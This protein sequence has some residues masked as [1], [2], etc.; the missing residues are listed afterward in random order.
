[1]HNEGHFGPLG[2]GFFIAAACLVGFA[3]GDFCSVADG[4]RIDCF[5]QLGASEEK[6]Q[7]R[8]CCWR[9]PTTTERKPN[10]E[11]NK[12]ENLRNLN[13]PYCFYPS[14]TVGYKVTSNKE[15]ATGF[16]L[17]LQLIGKGCAYGNDYKELVVN[18]AL[19]TQT[20][21]HVTIRD[22]S[23][24]RYR[25]PIKTPSVTSKSASQD[26]TLTYNE[27]NFSFVVKRKSNGAVIFNTALGPFFFSKQFIQITSVLPSTNVYGLGEHVLGLKL[28]TEWNL[29]TLF[30]RDIG[31]PPG[32]VNLYGVHPFYLNV[33]KDGNA[34]GVFLLNSNAMDIIL[35]PNPAITYRT[36]G[37]VLDFY[38]F[39][40][41][42]PND[43]IEQYTNVIGTSVVPPY[44]SLGFHLCR[45]GYGTLS[46]MQEVDKRM[47]DNNIPLDTQWNDIEYMQDH[48]DFTIGNEK[49][50]GLPEYVN[51]LHA[52]GMH[53]V[54]IVDPG[55]SNTHSDYEAY[56]RGLQLG[57]FVKDDNGQPIVGKVWPGNTV[58]PDFFHPNATQYWTEQISKFH[59]QI[60]FD[61]LWIDMNEPSNFVV[62]SL[63]GCP[64]SSLETPPYV[65][66][67]A[68]GSLSVQTLCMTAKHYTGR[69]YDLHSL[70]GYSEG[71]V[72]MN[73][74]NTVRKKRS[75]VIGRSTFS[76]SGAHQ[77]H[78]TGDNHAS[79]DD[80]AK[81]IP[82]ILNFQMF[83]IP[84]VGAD[85][86][87]F[88]GTT[89]E[90]LCS[91][92]MQLGAFYPFS[93]NHNTINV[94]AQDP[95]AFG[96]QL[97]VA[98]RNALMLR[99]ALLP[100]LYTL[101]Y[102]SHLH[103]SPVA[104]PLFFNFPKDPNT[105]DIDQQFMWGHALLISPV[106]KQ[107]ASSVQ[108]YFPAGQW[109]SINQ[110][111]ANINSTGKQYTLPGSF[112][113]PNVHI[114]GGYIVPGQGA[115]LTTTASRKNP[116]TVT[117][118]L[119]EG[120]VAYGNMFMD[121]GE[122]SDDMLLHYS[123]VTFVAREKTLRSQP[124]YT[125]YDPGTT[126]DNVIIYGVKQLPSSVS[127]NGEHTTNFN[128]NAKFQ[129]LTIE[130]MKLSLLK[131]NKISWQ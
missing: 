126:W 102:E 99:Y 71:I 123:N 70:Y 6:C 19:E 53:Y 94:A 33:E 66:S 74:L 48:L 69:H 55:I 79:W 32:G 16:Q 18:V 21:L 59:Q 131:T 85:I 35:Q 11:V 78:W 10:A 114:R 86:C 120:G 57:V 23:N 106:L 109:Y 76:G 61:G 29:L 42:T 65:P 31:D 46:R 112:E 108:A 83:G 93:R 121:D 37:G 24:E 64:K 40:G 110:I 90:E 38:F 89:T 34:N 50:S 125:N 22:P 62:G 111:S 43:V 127:V 41:P 95:A 68:G 87:G 107:G 47:K 75:L 104:R 56:N 84:L 124:G 54:M 8:G 27:D 58:Y 12:T 91:R 25:V 3:N 67:V 80:L 49:W 100:Y 128:Y 63:S 30:S 92:W 9:L 122:R 20:R 88:Q 2:L 96:Q 113:H 14:N 105:V 72:T 119:D 45:W 4:S 36:I 52:N 77:G 130:K 117:V 115:A 17:N 7:A 28:S 39:M 103:G 26:Y 101:F 97:I 98:S 15:T 44:W 129:A 60:Q 81:S 73:S 51:Q 5:P 13:T 116:F 118:G 1:M 82:G